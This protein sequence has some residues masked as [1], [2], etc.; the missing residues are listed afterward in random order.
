MALDPE[1][2][3]E[4]LSTAQT[5]WTILGSLGFVEGVKWGWGAWSARRQAKRDAAAAAAA[6]RDAAAA[7]AAQKEQRLQEAEKQEARAMRTDA[8]AQWQ[9]IAEER[10]KE[11][12]D[13]HERLDAIQK[14]VDE[15]K[16]DR[17]ALR[18]QLV[19]REQRLTK[20]EN[21]TNAHPQT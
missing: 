19:Q 11:K 15:C 21:G 6:A 12:H 18:S 16:E 20:V 5:V 17:A 7:A 4:G 8:V 14:E 9:A 3:K 2:I 10:A 1:A 13:C